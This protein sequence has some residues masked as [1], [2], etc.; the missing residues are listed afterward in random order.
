MNNTDKVMQLLAKI[1]TRREIMHEMVR[2][3]IKDR[4]KIKEIESAS[5][6]KKPWI[7]K[8]VKNDTT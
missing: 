5:E 3:N 8:R 6:E 1:Q 2:A 7:K 4:D